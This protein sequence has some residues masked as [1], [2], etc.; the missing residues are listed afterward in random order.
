[1]DAATQATISLSAN[2]ATTDYTTAQSSYNASYTEFKA[3]SRTSSTTDM[4]QELS[5]TYASVKLISQALE[6]EVNLIDT[7][8]NLLTQRNQP[9]TSTVTSQKTSAHNEL[10]SANSVLGQ[11]STEVKSLQSAKTALTSAEQDLQI[12]SIGNPTGASPY[13][14]AVEQNTVAQKQA[15][16]ASAEQALAEHTVRAPFDGTLASI[17]VETGDTAGSS[18]VASIITPKQVAEISV[19][20]VD[21]AK[22]S[23]GQKV[24]LTFDAIDGLTLTGT[25]AEVDAVGAVSQGVV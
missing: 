4:E 22:I 9:A 11:I 18:A 1:A 3:L 2:R 20:E 17:D 21:A 15:A 23:V 12:A 19:N 5:D 25:V 16:L 10:A 13:S 7:T 8:V 24:T 14:L 6:S